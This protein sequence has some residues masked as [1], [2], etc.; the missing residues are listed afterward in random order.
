MFYINQIGNLIDQLKS[1]TEFYNRGTNTLQECRD[2]LMFLK[3]EI[4]N[5]DAYRLFYEDKENE[6]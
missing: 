3:A 5:N 1:G 6:L 4:E 2:R